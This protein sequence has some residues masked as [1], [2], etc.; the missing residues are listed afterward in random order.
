MGSYSVDIYVHES[1]IGDWDLTSDEEVWFIGKFPQVDTNK[2]WGNRMVA[3]SVCHRA[4]KHFVK[5]SCCSK[6]DFW[7]QRRCRCKHFGVEYVV[8]VIK[9]VYENGKTTKKWLR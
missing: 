3:A 2:W 7:P 5:N 9:L 6:K 1:A 8:P 4:A